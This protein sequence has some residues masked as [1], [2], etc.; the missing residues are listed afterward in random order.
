MKENCEELKNLVEYFSKQLENRPLCQP[1]SSSDT[2]RT[3]KHISS[4]PVEVMLLILKFVVSND[5]DLRSLERFGMACKGFF[6]L[7]RENELWRKACEKVWKNNLL[8]Q[9]LLTW[10]DMFINRSRLRFDGCYISKITYQRLG[11]NSFQDQFYR[12]LHLIVYYRLLRFFPCGEMI[13]MTSADDLQMSVNKLQNKRA[14]QQSR[15]ILNGKYHYQDNHVLIVI[16]KKP[17]PIA[18]IKD[19]R[20]GPWIET[21]VSLHSF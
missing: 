16:K 19:L 18:I 9:P 5:L 2:I 10:R 15:E 12:P 21:I 17:M 20:K 13:M 3:E 1:S 11:E 14:A 4:L 6:I 7:S 8:T